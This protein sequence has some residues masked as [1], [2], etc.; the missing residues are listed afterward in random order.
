MYIKYNKNHV[1]L[2]R[3]LRKN[4]TKQEKRLWYNF[5]SAHPLKFVKQKVIENYIVDFFCKKANLIVEVDG[6]QHYTEEGIVYDELRTTRLNELGFKV[7]RV[8][9]YD[10]NT[11]MEGVA[12]FINDTIFEILGNVYEEE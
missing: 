12:R 10:I 4:M 5:L 2:A 9:N 8:T 11:N 6:E 1:T 7:I 3:N